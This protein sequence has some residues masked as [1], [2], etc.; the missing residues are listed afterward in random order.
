MES[1]I[2]LESDDM[3]G[4]CIDLN[5][6]KIA[7]RNW[8]HLAR[9]F[10]VPREIYKDFNPEKPLRPT[11]LLFEWISANRRDLTVRQLRAALES[12]DRNDVVRVLRKYLDELFSGQE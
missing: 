2:E 5:N 7:V 10:N 4:I 6:P 12:I 1:V 8:R 9:A 11:N 3:R